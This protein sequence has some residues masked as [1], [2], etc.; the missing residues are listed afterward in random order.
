MSR[1]FDV[2]DVTVRPRAVTAAATAAKRGRMV[3]LPTESVYALLADAFSAR[4]VGAV[5]AAKQRPDTSALPVAVSSVRML[6]GIAERLPGQ[7]QTLV[8]AFWP[9]PLTL[10]CRQQPS[11]QWHAGGGG[12]AL[13]VRM[14]LHPV[15]LDVIAEIGPCVLIAADGA[16]A[17][18][19]SADEAS[20]ADVVLDAG[21]R[22][23][24][25]SPSTVVDVRGDHPVLVRE[26]A[27]S[28]ER[29][30]DVVPSLRDAEATTPP[31]TVVPPTEGDVR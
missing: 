26:G 10:V 21:V 29:L 25:G 17:L 6:R 1:R 13:T 19:P 7:G 23:E 31:P 15:A 5:R 14:P 16:A 28:R 8:D 4:G 30:A 11:L 22:T 20:A 3:L 2:R 27:L 18:D 24:P 12:R 9:G